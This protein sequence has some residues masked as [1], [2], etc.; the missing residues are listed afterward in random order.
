MLLCPFAELVIPPDDL[1]LDLLNTRQRAFMVM[2]VEPL[3]ESRRQVESVMRPRAR[4]SLPAT[5]CIAWYFFTLDFARSPRSSNT[6]R[7]TPDAVS[8]A[9]ST[10][11]LASGSISQ[12]WVVSHSF[13]WI[14]EFGFSS[15]VSSRAFVNVASRCR[16]SSTTAAS[17][18]VRSKLIPVSLMR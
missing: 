14:G 10:S 3:P 13:N 2:Q 7:T 9:A 15:P 11:A 17:A 16:S 6:S 12:P 1:G 8:R 18:K 4:P 5:L